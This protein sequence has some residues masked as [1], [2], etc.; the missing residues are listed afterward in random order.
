MISEKRLKKEV[1]NVLSENKNLEIKDFEILLA[2]SKSQNK[3][4]EIKRVAACDMIVK[5]MFGFY[6]KEPLVPWNFFNSEIGKLILEMKFGQENTD[7]YFVKEVAKMLDKTYQNINQE[8]KLGNLKAYKRGGTTVI[9]RRDLEKYIS[10]RKDL[11]AKD[12]NY[13]IQNEQIIIPKK[14]R[15]E[16]YGE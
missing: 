7:I 12:I 6:Y 15:E 4:D 13:S 8:I 9:Y 3:A 10:N 2:L 11:E 16:K 1:A 14:E 5:K